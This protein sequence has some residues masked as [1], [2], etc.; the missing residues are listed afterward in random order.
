MYGHKLLTNTGFSDLTLVELL[1][2]IFEEPLLSKKQEAENNLRLENEFVNSLKLEI[3]E[4]GW[5]F[6]W[7]SE[8]S[9]D[10]RWIWSL[11]RQDD[12]MLTG[13]IRE[14]SIAFLSLPKKGEFERLPFFA[15]RT[16]GNPHY[17]DISESGGR[18]LLHLLTVNK[19]T[20][21]DPE[22][23]FPK[24]TEEINDIL[25]EYGLLRDDLWNFVTVQGMIAYYQGEIHPVWNAAVHTRT[26][27]N[28]PM[29]ELARL[30]T[31]QPAS[32]QMVWIVEN[33]SVASTIM[34]AV[35]DAT[36]VCTHGQLRAASWRLLDRLVEEECTLFY[37]GDLDPE[38][39]QIADR[40]K[41]RYQEKLVLWRMDPLAY[42]SS[43]SNEDIAG[44]ISKLDGVSSQEL[45]DLV[46][47]MC[48]KK[49]AGY[50]EALV[51]KLIE[52][53]KQAQ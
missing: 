21:E 22:Y 34:D 48:M 44:R 47:M 19:K 30:E 23:L 26:V 53:I 17:F 37:S 5:W 39:V 12:L 10:T 51:D 33:S 6:E 18:L 31:I 13:M 8:R 38:G 24:S 36:V 14:V 9:P 16:T 1:E 35:P 15:Q 46:K 50:Q 25:A 2:G 4:V 3:P 52:D 45:V 7:I 11:Y 41:K 49:K 28:V 43:L 40:L 32:G 20:R 29:K 27:W 42:E